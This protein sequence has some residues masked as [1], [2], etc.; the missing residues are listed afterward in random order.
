MNREVLVE[1]HLP[2]RAGQCDCAQL[3]LPLA[4]WGGGCL[5]RGLFANPVK[6]GLKYGDG[7]PEWGDAQR[8][9]PCIPHLSG[10]GGC[11]GAQG[12]G[13]AAPPSPVP[14][15]RGLRPISQCRGFVF[16]FKLI[17]CAFYLL[18]L[19]RQRVWEAA[20]RRPSPGWPSRAL[21]ASWPG[22][23][24]ALS[25]CALTP[26]CAGRGW[27]WSPGPGCIPQKK[28]LFLPFCALPCRNSTG[29]GLA[30]EFFREEA[31]GAGAVWGKHQS[32]GME[33]TRLVAAPLACRTQGDGSTPGA[34]MLRLLR[35]Q[36]PSAPAALPG[37][38]P[39]VP[40][41]TCQPPHSVPPAFLRG[42]G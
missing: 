8:H 31:E 25:A 6:K 5:L 42:D 18:L 35:A 11:W 38:V 29:C 34:G 13:P 23:L 41:E 22:I 4:C 14:H 17:P 39:P 3:A 36:C 24:S 1:S 20:V 9:L 10:W 26:H 32:A 21:G 37:R 19:W 30:A 33:G 2:G 28:I 15:P 7:Y 27:G 16:I 40:P 12:R